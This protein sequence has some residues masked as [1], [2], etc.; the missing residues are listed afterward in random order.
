MLPILKVGEESVLVEAMYKM[1]D[2]PELCFKVKLQTKIINADK[3]G[4]ERRKKLV[5]QK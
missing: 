1:S 3:G 5:L 4:H 2:I